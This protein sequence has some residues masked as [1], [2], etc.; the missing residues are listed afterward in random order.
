MK[1]LN[2]TLYTYSSCVL[3]AQCDYFVCVLVLTAVQTIHAQCIY[4][5]EKVTVVLN[6]DGGYECAVK[7]GWLRVVHMTCLIHIMCIFSIR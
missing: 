7:P 4:V 3:T 6:V 5:F 1:E 2:L